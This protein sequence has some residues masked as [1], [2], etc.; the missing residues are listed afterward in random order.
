MSTKTTFKR[1]ALVAVASLGFGVLTS[2]APASAAPTSGLTA[3]ASVTVVGVNKSGVAGTG[4]LAIYTLNTSDVDGA[5]NLNALESITAVV[6]GL[7]AAGNGYTPATSDLRFLEVNTRTTG[8]IDTTA[9]GLLA[10]DG[11]ITS[12]NNNCGW[13]GSQRTTNLGKYCFGVEALAGKALDRG[14]YTITWYLNDTNGNQRAVATSKYTAVS[15][16]ATS[17]AILTAAALGNPVAGTAWTSSASAYMSATLT[18]ANGGRIVLS[19]TATLSSIMPR[20]SATLENATTEA[21]LNTLYASDTGTAWT[22]D[23]GTSTTAVSNNGTYLLVPASDAVIS[24]SISTTAAST[25][26]V[27][28]GTASATASITALPTAS[29]V[30]TAS[31]FA[32]SGAGLVMSSPTTDTTTANAARTYQAPLSTTSVTMSWII[33]NAAGT[34]LVNEPV[35]ITTAWTGN[36]AGSVTPVSGA[37]G[38]VVKRSDNTGLV[39]YTITQSNPLTGSQAV[40]SV[41]G[42][43][44]SGV[45]Y[46]DTTVLWRVPTLTTISTSPSANFK[47]VA[48]SSVSVVATA[49]DQFGAPMAG[50][51]LQPGI[52]GTTSPNYTATAKATLTTGADGT[53]TYTIT[54]GAA[55]TTITDTVT[56]TGAAGTVAATS[57]V[58]TYVAAL[59]VAATLTGSYTL[60]QSSSTYANLFSTAAIT[61]ANTGLVLDRTLDTSATISVAGTSSSDAQFAMR[62]QALDSALAAVTG[63]PVVVTATDGAW[64]R[65]SSTAKVVKTL[66]LYPDADGY[67]YVQAVLTKSGTS[68][69][70][71]TSGTTVLTQT[72]SAKNATADARNVALTATGS[73]VTATVT[74]RFGNPVAGINVQLSTS[75]GTLGNGQKTSVYTTNTSGQIAIVVDVDGATTVTAYLSDANDSTSI[76]GYSGTSI[77]DATVPAG[78]RTAT[79]AVTGTGTLSG[80]AQAAVDAAAEATDAANAATDAANAAAEAADAATAAAQDAADAVAALSTQVSEMVNA[81]K[82]QIT[83]LT[84]LVIKIQKKVRA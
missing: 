61:Q 14:T 62:V 65:S 45:A 16:A 20:L 53:A 29:N 18:D 27:L 59:P 32:I 2:V 34:A 23:F 39:T 37:T 56:F 38:A 42:Q 57:R 60:D 82:K 30:S 6:T 7:P 63:V 33:R 78:I 28:F 75:V 69:Y 21:V 52:S 67:V 26:R 80:T 47:A 72:V 4:G 5:A 81:L 74:D 83:A 46:G 84:N 55:S 1:I 48:A 10:T 17:G 73:D 22:T 76:A 24:S 15:T 58:I 54:G 43:V 66:S 71:F 12:A 50:V 40:V 8:I 68:T 77:I 19:D 25:I 35:T 3:D 13:T 11:A 49:R 79:L 31:T 44:T 41:A 64:M 36:N 51:V 70:T 9:V